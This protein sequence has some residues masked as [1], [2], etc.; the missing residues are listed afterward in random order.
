[1]YLLIEDFY[2]ALRTVNVLSHAFTPIKTPKQ[3]KTCGP[4][5]LTGVGHQELKICLKTLGF[6]V[7]E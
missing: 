7:K 4:D 3:R 2:D 6:I 1:L 5:F